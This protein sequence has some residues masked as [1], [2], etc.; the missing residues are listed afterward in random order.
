MGLWDK[1]K[2]SVSP[3]DDDN[4]Y[5]DDEF[6]DEYTMGNYNEMGVGDMPVSGGFS[7]QQNPVYSQN[8]PSYNNYQNQQQPINNN[9]PPH[10]TTSVTSLSSERGSGSLEIKM[11][12]P[13]SF[14]DGRRIADLLMSRK[15][16]IVNFEETKKEIIIKLLDFM[17]GIAYV[18][19]SQLNRTSEKTFMLTPPGA[20]FSEDVIKNAER[21]EIGRD[22]SIY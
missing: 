13:E 14:T 15:T 12:K 1:I 10:P 16:V 5:D 18:T 8:A 21:G 2:K 7:Q 9:P 6:E 11:V 20:T 4:T 3:D 19:K 17:T 22:P